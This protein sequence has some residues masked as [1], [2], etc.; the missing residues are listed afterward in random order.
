MRVRKWSS[1]DRR[2][3]SERGYGHAWQKLRAKAL[4]RDKGL[5]QQ[6][7]RDGRTVVAKDVDHIVPKHR[8]GTDDLGNLQSLCSPCHQAKTAREGK[9][10]R[11]SRG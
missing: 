10:A 8:G 6:C 4:E 5:C 11:G 1:P 3:A 7:L 2:S 9:A